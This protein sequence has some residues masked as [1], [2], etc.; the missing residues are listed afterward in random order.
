[1]LKWLLI[2]VIVAAF[3]GL[4]A[5]GLYL[6][7]QDELAPSD[8]IV[9]VSGGDTEARAAMAIKLYQEGWAPLII[10]SGA[11][12]D[13]ESISNA[14][15]MKNIA[16]STGIPP[17]V[18]AIEELSRNTIENA[19]EVSTIIGALEF[20]RVILVTSPYHQRRTYLEFQKILGEEV[21]IINHSAIDEDWSKSGWWRS[22]R[23]WYLSLSELPK[24]GL[25]QLINQ[26]AP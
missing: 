1:M 5:I 2:G 15:A 16:V 3:G 7:P 21:E 13:P 19:G 6:S 4:A 9:A 17:D 8:A 12:S 20:D 11:A 23:G 14:R 24:T 25:A 26:F 22:P 10:F 18:V